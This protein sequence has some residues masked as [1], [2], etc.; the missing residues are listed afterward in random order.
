MSSDT[1]DLTDQDRRHGEPDRLVTFTDGVFA[2]VITILVLE[3]KVPDLSSGQR[4]AESLEEMRP[5]FVAFVISFL[6][7]GMYWVGHRDMF[8][9]VRFVN[10]DVLWLNLLF[11]LPVALVPFAASV[12]GEYPDEAAALHLYG[13]VLIVVTLMRML[14]YW[15]LLRHPGLLWEPPSRH[16]RRFAILISGVPLVAY[17]IAMLVASSVPWLSLML[18]AVLPLLYFGLIT[19][20]RS[21]S[22]TRTAAR[23]FS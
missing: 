17:V 20:L 9:G 5:T 8:T 12:V 6:L 2:I 16:S 3:L 18:Y 19:F 13:A 22:R 4:L 1:T 21:D 15:Y 7:V 10:R 11:L 23:Q 14:L